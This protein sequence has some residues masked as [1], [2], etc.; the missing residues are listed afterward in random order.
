MG[1]SLVPLDSYGVWDNTVRTERGGG[2]GVDA[3]YR[4]YYEV[5]PSSVAGASEFSG[6]NA[7]MDE[8][9]DEND[10]VKSEQWS[11]E[12]HSEE[13]HHSGGWFCECSWLAPILGP[14]E[15]PDEVDGEADGAG[16]A[17]MAAA[18]TEEAAAAVAS[19]MDA[20]RDAAVSAT[21]SEKGKPSFRKAFGMRASK[22]APSVKDKYAKKS[23][24]P[25]NV[26]KKKGDPDPPPKC[27][28]MT[29][30]SRKQ[31]TMELQIA[32]PVAADYDIE[33]TGPVWEDMNKISVKDLTSLQP[34][35]AMAAASKAVVAA[36]PL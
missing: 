25:T 7:P 13:S 19:V 27:P 26:K 6:A 21:P 10:E 15:L 5:A 20:E 17:Q 16:D 11:T 14:P 36:A 2:F 28:W 23:A 35:A 1:P 9:G 4:P 18:G 29:G 22:A 12:S 31:R 8:S 24:A 3:T 33:E 34:T 30:I 32:R